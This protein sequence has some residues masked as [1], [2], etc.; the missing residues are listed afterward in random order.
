MSCIKQALKTY[1]AFVGSFLQHTHTHSAGL[2][3][4]N[5]GAGVPWRHTFDLFGELDPVR[6]SERAR[7][8]VNIVNVQ[9]LAHELNDRLGLVER[10]G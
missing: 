9:D 2:W 6:I 7:L 10:S 3:L 5:P 8:L 4:N 1:R